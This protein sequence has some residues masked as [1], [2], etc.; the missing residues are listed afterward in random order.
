MSALTMAAGQGHPEIVLA[1]IR[2]ERCNCY[3]IIAEVAMDIAMRNGHHR[4]T[5]LMSAWLA[6]EDMQL[7]CDGC[8]KHV[9]EKGGLMKCGRC[10]EGKYCGVDCQKMNRKEHKE[11]CR[12]S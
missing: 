5:E 4:C 12:Q 3:Q 10:G 7:V 1:L 11:K 6:G 2:D 9:P 8:Y